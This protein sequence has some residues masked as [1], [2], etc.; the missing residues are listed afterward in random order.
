MRLRYN[1]GT[2][3]VAVAAAFGLAGALWGTFAWVNTSV[4]KCVFRV[5]RSPRQRY[6]TA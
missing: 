4:R 2:P 3:W 5:A 1:D 6:G